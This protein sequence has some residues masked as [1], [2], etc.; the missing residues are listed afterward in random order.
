VPLGTGPSIV[1]WT[2]GRLTRLARRLVSTHFAVWTDFAIWTHLAIWTHFTIWVQFL[3][4]NALRLTPG[5]LCPLL[6]FLVLAEPLLEAR[7]R[8]SQVSL[9]V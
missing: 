1:R 7:I 4:G 3:C 5:L 6:A 9:S 8:F 2:I